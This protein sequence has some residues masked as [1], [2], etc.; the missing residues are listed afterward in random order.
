M[1][2]KNHLAELEI[3]SGALRG[4]RLTLFANRLVH[5]PVFEDLTRPR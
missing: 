4:S 1:T 2:P 5:V 3:S